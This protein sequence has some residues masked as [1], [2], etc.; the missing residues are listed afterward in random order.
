MILFGTGWNFSLVAILVGYMV[1]GAVKTGSR[2][3]GGRFYQFLAI[4]LTYSALVGMFLPE[5]W[6]ALASGPR[7]R[8]EAA[9]DVG[10]IAQ[11]EAKT[12]SKRKS[13]SKPAEKTTQP[14]APAG[15]DARAP[16]PAPEASNKTASAARVAK[17]RP[18]NAGNTSRPRSILYLVF[19]LALT[20][21]LL[22]GLIYSIPIML[23]IH[24]PI[25]LV[26]FGIALWQAWR[27]NGANDVVVT[28]PYRV[29]A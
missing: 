1:G 27:M 23:G 26:I 13:E 19:M 28:G 11:K 8:K 21:V 24:S 29:R 16:K 4:F 6:D 10:K 14:R 18:E 20:I 17:N 15:L 5:A 25:S 12:G 2:G 3:W 22:V 9:N 7:E